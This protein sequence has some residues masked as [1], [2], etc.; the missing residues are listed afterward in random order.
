VFGAD[1]PTVN[2]ALH[3]PADQ[4]SVSTWS[5]GPKPASRPIDLAHATRKKL[6]HALFDLGTV[7]ENILSRASGAKAEAGRIVDARIDYVMA[8]D[9]TGLPAFEAFDEI[10]KPVSFSYCIYSRKNDFAFDSG[11]GHYPIILDLSD[12]NIIIF[13]QDHIL[14]TVLHG[15]PVD[16]QSVGYGF[17][18]L[19]WILSIFSLKFMI[20]MRR[21]IGAGLII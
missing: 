16:R 21:V 8:N 5:K 3:A 15:L 14:T 19:L 7:V 2:L 20:L 9:I 12:Q 13:R 10:G 4:V 11:G 18:C 17:I 1:V 6:A